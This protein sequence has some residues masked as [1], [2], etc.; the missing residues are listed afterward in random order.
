MLRQE[1]A[2]Y[3]IGKRQPWGSCVMELKNGS[4]R[5]HL[6]VQG[7]KPLLYEAYV[8]AGEECIFCGELWPEDGAG[9]SRRR[10]GGKGRTDV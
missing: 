7:L 5:L 2:G 4:G 10:T 1:T 3:G 9:G 6:T 8:M